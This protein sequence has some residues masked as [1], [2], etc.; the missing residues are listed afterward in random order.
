MPSGGD[1]AYFISTMDDL[2]L[3]LADMQQQILDDTYADLLLNSFPKEIVFIRQMHPRDRSFTPEKI[4]QTVINFPIDELSRK[5]SAPTV[6]GRGAAM[7]AASRSD[8]SHQCKAFGHYHR[9]WL[10]VANTNGSKRKPKKG[11]KGRSGD[12]SPKWCSYHKT[13]THSDAECHNCLLYTSPSP[14]D[15]RQSRM[16]SSA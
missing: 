5:S 6:T 4:K 8:Q 12:P 15:K 16:P 1:P 3:R 9:D 14:R 13:N 7:A 10:G 2:R 11:K